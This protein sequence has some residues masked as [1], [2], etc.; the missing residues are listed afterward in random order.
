MDIKPI[1]PQECKASIKIDPLIIE[2]V[3]EY[4]LES[5]RKD[6]ARIYQKDLVAAFIARKD[7]EGESWTESK[8]IDKG[9]FDFRAYYEDA[10][11]KVVYESPCFG[12]SNFDAYFD[13]NG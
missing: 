9:V 8:M 11:W 4:I 13:F 3:N 5:Y 12:D 1:T 10:G 6:K 7:R 2:I